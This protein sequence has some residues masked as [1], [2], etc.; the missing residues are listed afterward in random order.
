MSEEMSIQPRRQASRIEHYPKT[1]V[2]LS[3]YWSLLWRTFF[4]GG[5]FVVLVIILSAVVIILFATLGMDPDVLHAFALLLGG[6]FGTAAGVMGTVFALRRV[7]GKT[8]LGHR[9]IL[10]Q[11]EE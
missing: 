4:W 10:L 5:I 9:L 7:L 8:F 1:S 2:L 11:P 3:I 6:I